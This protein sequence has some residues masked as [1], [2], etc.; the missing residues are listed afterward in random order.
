M[1]IILYK[2]NITYEYTWIIDVQKN[3]YEIVYFIIYFND[4]MV[5][6]MAHLWFLRLCT[7]LIVNRITRHF[8]N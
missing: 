8:I 5:L 7:V 6:T 1:Y 2:K 3:A 4:D